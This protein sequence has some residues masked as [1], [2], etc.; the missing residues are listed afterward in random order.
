MFFPF[1]QSFLKAYIYY[2][3]SCTIVSSKSKKTKIIS[4]ISLFFVLIFMSQAHALGFSDIASVF[5][6]IVDPVS[7]F[8]VLVI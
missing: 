2:N 3:V 7:C 4:L 1:W 6:L 5:S 8:M